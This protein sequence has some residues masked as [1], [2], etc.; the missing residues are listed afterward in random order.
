MFSKPLFIHLIKTNGKLFSIITG[1]LILLIGVVMSIFTPETMQEIAEA[2]MDAPVNPLGDITT[3]IA[4]V[5]NQYFGNFALI[6]GIIYSIIMGN[7]LIADQVDKGS[8]AYHL[9]TP[10]TRSQYTF[11]SAVYFVS[12]LVVMFGL[13][14]AAGYGVAEIV[15]P[16]ELPVAKFFALT[17]GSLLLHLAISGITFFASCLFNRSSQS[18]ALGAGLAVFFYAANILSGMSD[19]LEFLKNVTIITLYDT[20]AIVQNESYGGQLVLLAVLTFVLYFIGMLVFK[21]KDLPL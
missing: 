13:V 8:M 18:L 17:A 3:L 21:R 12:S 20:N 9:S 10:I 15:Q 6:F 7:K 11:T 2:S 1:A 19:S 5:A 4:F 14:F 16:G